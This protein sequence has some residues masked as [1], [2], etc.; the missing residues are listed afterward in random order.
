[1]C[2]SMRQIG[3]DV[4]LHAVSSDEEGVSVSDVYGDELMPKIRLQ[5]R[6]KLRGVGGLKYGYSV[7]KRIKSENGISDL[8][9]ARDIYSLY[10]M[11]KVM[12]LPNIYEAHMPPRTV[13][14]K[15]L[16]RSIIKNK[17][18]RGL[19]AVSE[20]LK[21]YYLKLYPD[22][23]TDQT[24]FV[25]PNGAEKSQYDKTEIN[26]TG[27][28]FRVG[29]FGSLQPHKGDRLIAELAL[30]MPSVEF[31]V[32]GPVR[33]DSW[34]KKNV[35]PKNIIMHGKLSQRNIVHAM[36]GCAILL[37]PYQRSV[38]RNVLEDDTHWGSPLKIFEYMALGLPII[39]SDVAAVVDVLD[40]N[41]GAIICE[42]DDTECWR[43]SIEKLIQDEEERLRRGSGLK[44]LFDA[45]YDRT[46]RM[47][48]IIKWATRY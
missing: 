42:C 16:L 2:R 43:I 27:N 8:V 20:R 6:L 17:N 41:S 46:A 38:A 36:S 3:H 33:A 15:H 4:T 32:A 44:A 22:L 19:V 12:S 34:F 18:F 11:G 28:A 13:L 29:Y 40:R 7:A 5:P 10:F 21:N 1:M 31:H 47:N 24:V 30:L 25:A 23:L 48:D 39:A 45:K 14:Q 35:C 37:A 9:Y 26:Y